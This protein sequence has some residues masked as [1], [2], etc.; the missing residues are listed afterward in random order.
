MDLSGGTSCGIS[1]LEKVPSVARVNG[2]SLESDISLNPR[3]LTERP[4][5]QESVRYL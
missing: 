2:N 4:P 3:L 5:S 1:E